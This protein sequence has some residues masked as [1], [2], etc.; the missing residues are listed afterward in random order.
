MRSLKESFDTTTAAVLAANSK[1]KRSSQ[2]AGRG[3]APERTQRLP[4]TG[5]TR[6]CSRSWQPREIPQKT[7]D[8]ET[9]M[10][11]SEPNLCQDVVVDTWRLLQGRINIKTALRYNNKDFV[12]FAMEPVESS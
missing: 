10:K 3:W 2:G 1:M 6:P 12:A 4:G 7:R 5:T 11:L 9:Q 8:G